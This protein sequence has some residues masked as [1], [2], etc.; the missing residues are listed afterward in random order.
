[1]AAEKASPVVC[2]AGVL[3]AWLS[4]VLGVQIASAAQA[5]AG[6]RVAAR[7]AAGEFAPALAAAAEV[8]SVAE[9][10]A[11]LAQIAG[12]Q[13]GSGAWTASL[14]T[15]AGIDDDRARAAALSAVAQTPLGGRGGG[16]MA[17]FDSLIQLITSTVQPE[18][19]EDVGG[20]GSVAPFA[21][22][23]YIDPDGTLQMAVATTG[24][25]R[26]AAL[27]SGEA[28]GGGNRDARRSSSL[29][30]ISLPRLEKQLQLRAAARKGP[31]EEMDLLAGLRRIQYVFVYPET[32]DLVIA[33]PAGGWCW[34]DEGRIVSTETSE[35]VVRLEDL[36]VVLRRMMSGDDLRLGCLIVPTQE[37][38]ARVK[39]FAE[40]SRRQPLKRG[41]RD[42]WLAQLREKLGKQNL[43]VYG[44]DPRTRIA[45]V[46]LEADYRMKLV[47][48]GI[49]KGV[50]G[51]ESYLDLARRSRETPSAM[52]VLRWW[53]TL[54]YDS[55]LASEDR[56]AFA[57]R[58]PGAQVLSENELLAASGERI[59]TGKSDELNRQFAEAFTKHFEQ[60]GEAY[61]IYAE[62]RNVCDLAA[63]CALVRREALAERIGWDMAFLGDD[64][65]F[66][67]RLGPPPRQVDS[68]IGYRVLGRGELLVGVSGGVR[69]DPEQVLSAGSMATETGGEVSGRRAASPPPKRSENVWWWD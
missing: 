59:H 2:A 66:P 52:T 19:W 57:F 42:W 25:D 47:G 14:E 65:N 12:A 4:L 35:P 32:R 45:A 63:A 50:P 30:K 8:A 20:A 26:L 61:P 64:A 31:T 37:G 39:A 69:V 51:V 10:D 28:A 38:L 33:G 27:R 13:A 22:G 1:M 21:T 36:V 9:R 48:M 53:F 29:R 41:Q 7:I 49:E 23:V 43:E 6:D 34:G 17:D 18:T 54:S 68:V 5:G 56:M 15:A 60:L 11:L 46:M 62:L 24:N 40:E 55:I 58:G 16:A 3:T 67:V 44:I